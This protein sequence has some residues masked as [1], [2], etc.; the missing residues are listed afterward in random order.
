MKPTNGLLLCLLVLL[1][2]PLALGEELTVTLDLDRETVKTGQPITANWTIAGGQSPYIIN[3]NWWVEE[4]DGNGEAYMV[5][6][7]SSGQAVLIPETGVTG[8]FLMDVTDVNGKCK[9]IWKDFTITG[10][11]ALLDGTITLDAD[12][13]A[14]G[15]PIT[16][17]WN[18]TG[19][20]E[21]Y[22]V[23][24]FW[25]IDE[26]NGSYY[27]EPA[28]IIDASA[29]YAFDFPGTGTFFL[30]VQDAREK[31]A[32]FSSAEFTVFQGADSFRTNLSL[33]KNTV[34][35][36][37]PI[38]ASWHLSGGNSAYKVDK[39]DWIF[40]EADGN[41]LTFKADIVGETSTTIPMAGASG[42][43]Q[44]W[45]SRTSPMRIVHVDS[46]TFTITGTRTLDETVDSI[47]Q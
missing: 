4:A 31:V 23:S 29:T 15:S 40:T 3:A 26:I 43:L 6:D 42:V 19:G 24:G 33:D 35:A 45:L 7:S 18:I 27:S 22:I 17:R 14:A 21:P 39:A 36:G 10:A 16:A 11:P 30:D 38:T 28:H 44:L 5:P 12:S 13:V 2:M 41:K 34:A 37:Q 1:V 9:W 20:K 32:R 25:T 47:A 8:S 46:P